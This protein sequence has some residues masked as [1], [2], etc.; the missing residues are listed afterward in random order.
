MT[1][2]KLKDICD[3]GSSNLKQKDVEALS[4][5]Y[6]V[7]GA[8][9]LINNIPFY[10]QETD[11]I[12]IVKDGSGIGRVVFLPAKSSVIGTMQY[13]LPKKGYNIKYIAYCLQSL[14]LSKY[15]QG[16]AIPHIYFRDYGE[17]VVNVTESEQEQERI[18][19]YLD[20]QFA[21]IDAMKANAAKA[22]AEAKALFQSVLTEAM[23]PKEGWIIIEF[24]KTCSFIRGPFGGSL[25]KDCFKDSG[26]A[27]YEQQ[28]AIYNRFTF[29]YFVDQNKFNEMR[30]FATK[31]G[32]LIM[33]C[34]GTIGRVAIIPHNAPLGII[35]QALLMI[36]PKC[37]NKYFLK[38][39]MESSIFKDIIV[40]N[41]D[42]AAIKNIASVSV[43][44][45][46]NVSLPPLP[47]QER[48][49]TRLD[50]LSAKVAALEGNYTQ[51]VAECDA[52]KQALLREVFE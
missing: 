13:I 6:P 47:E 34:S 49:V 5:E 19:A 21:K 25:K 23:T 3:K 12:A 36:E 27:V 26:Y 17:R 18:V 46:I 14:D 22:L 39:Y 32:N 41:S 31:E 51:T 1:Q 24:G 38:Y 9:G 48:I 40:K 29:R 11:Y 50:A 45:S 28:N 2:K 35:N 42:G 4:G 15:K 44:K 43:L 37:F 20:M 33:S 8:S 30:R 52:L 10:Q 16:A 7:F